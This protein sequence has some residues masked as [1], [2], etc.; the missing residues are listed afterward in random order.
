MATPGSSGQN[1]RESVVSISDLLAE[2]PVSV[3]ADRRDSDFVLSTMVSVSC[4]CS[5]CQEEYEA[6][7]DF[8][9][10]DLDES[11]KRVRRTLKFIG[12]V[13]ENDPETGILE[14]FCPVC[15]ENLKNNSSS[16]A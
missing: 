8:A 9:V 2:Y 14:N 15:W 1:D 11:Q 7:F 3:V 16:T 5:N 12:W 6:E 4:Q 13:F 10:V